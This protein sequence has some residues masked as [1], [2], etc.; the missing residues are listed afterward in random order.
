MAYTQI[1]SNVI[2][3][4][5]A[6]F[7]VIK[8]QFCATEFR[9]KTLI[10]IDQSTLEIFNGTLFDTMSDHKTQNSEMIKI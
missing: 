5:S 4:N 9:F 10:L 3:R 6:Q 7:R 8:A 2:P 1:A